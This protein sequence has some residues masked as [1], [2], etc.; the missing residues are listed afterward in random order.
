[1]F[2]S[3]TGQVILIL[4]V[5]SRASHLRILDLVQHHRQ[6]IHDCMPHLLLQ[7]VSCA[8]NLSSLSNLSMLKEV[9]LFKVVV[10]HLTRFQR[11]ICDVQRNETF[12]AHP[13]TYKNPPKKGRRD[14]QGQRYR[15]M[16]ARVMI[17]KIN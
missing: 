17:E 10:L 7:V 6:W 8:E 1:M 11:Q 14:Q 15:K 16:A 5:H 3:H 13:H 2:W 12:G 4:H 9:R